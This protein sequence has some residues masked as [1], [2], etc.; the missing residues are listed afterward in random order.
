MIYLTTNTD[1]FIKLQTFSLCFF[2]MTESFKNL[3]NVL[4]D[5][6]TENVEKVFQGC[7][8]H[9]RQEK[10][11]KRCFFAK[12]DSQKLLKQSQSSEAN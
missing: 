7:N 1:D 2:K 12:N 3:G 4:T 11:R 8:R 10:S 9:E 6:A 5:W